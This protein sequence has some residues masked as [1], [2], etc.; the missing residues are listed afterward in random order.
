MKII[1]CIECEICIAYEGL[2]DP[3]YV[4]Q[5]V[6]GISLR[7]AKSLGFGVEDIQQ[8]FFTISWKQLSSA[9][10]KQSHNWEAY[11]MAFNRS[12]TKQ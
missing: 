5:R 8:S 1:S 9:F 10:S 2:S 3:I 4:M 12:L 6:L 7:A 11:A